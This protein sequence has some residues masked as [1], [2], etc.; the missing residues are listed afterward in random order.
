[1]T[2]ASFRLWRLP[3]GRGH[4]TD[5]TDAA[6]TLLFAISRGAW[7]AGLCELFD[8]PASLLPEVRDCAGDFGTTDVF[9]GPIRILGIAGDQQAATV[10]Q[11]CFAPGMMKATFGTGAFALLNTGAAPVVSRNRLLATVAYQL[12]G[13]RTYALEGAIFV[14]GAAVQWLRDALE[15]IGAAPDGDA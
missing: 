5:A 9:G 10:G 13:R 6:R 11:G 4:R 3:G 2:V 12:G 7:D 14:A 15:V 1:G 8:L